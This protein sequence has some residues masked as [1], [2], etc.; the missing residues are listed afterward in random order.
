MELGHLYVIFKLKNISLSSSFPVRL[1]YAEWVVCCI[2]QIQTSV[3]CH[4]A[5]LERSAC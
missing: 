4:L 3:P 1:K 5:S 2:S